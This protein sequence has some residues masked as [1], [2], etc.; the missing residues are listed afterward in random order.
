MSDTGG[1]SQGFSYDA[2]GNMWQSSGTVLNNTRPV[3][4]VDNGSNQMTTAA[5]DPA[6]NQTTIPN[7]AG[8]ALSYDAEGR[9]I[10]VTESGTTTYQY[11]GEGK[12]SK[13][14]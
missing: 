9:V 5:Y 7:L 3:S 10:Q 6:G 1:L 2:L 8:T 12:R 13:T 14:K 4:N 11:D